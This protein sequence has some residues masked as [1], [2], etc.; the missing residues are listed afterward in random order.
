VAG[1]CG[2]CGAPLEL[3]DGGKCVWC[4]A[5]IRVEPPAQRRVS[6]SRASLVPEGTDD[7]FTVSPFLFLLLAV[8]G[9][10]L[11]SQ[12]AVQDYVSAHP[13]LGQQIRALSTAVSAAGVRVRDAGLVKDSFS[14]TLE[15]YTPEEVWTFDLAVDVVAML[16]GLD[17]LPGNAR[18]EIASDLQ[19]LD[20]NVHSHHWKKEV[21]RAGVGPEAFRVLRAQVPRHTPH[22]GR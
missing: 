21:S 17:G 13:G 10:G 15:P 6:G 7:C 20:R 4:H 2:N 12:Q 11:S 19:S 14:E 22:P 8:L 5:Q 16:G 1:V 9:S 3:D 18:A